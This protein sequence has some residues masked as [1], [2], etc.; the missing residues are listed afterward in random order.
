MRNPH[1]PRQVCAT[2]DSEPRHRQATRL[3]SANPK[4]AN[5]SVKWFTAPCPFY[6]PGRHGR[7][8]PYAPAAAPRRDV[9]QGA[10]KWPPSSCVIWMRRVGRRRA[11]CCWEEAR[12]GVAGAKIMQD[13]ERFPGQQRPLGWGWEKWGRCNIWRA[14]GPD[15]QSAPRRA[16]WPVSAPNPAPSVSLSLCSARL[17]PFHSGFP[18]C[19][20]SPAFLL[21]G[22]PSLP[23]A[24]PRLRHRDLLARLHWLL[25]LRSRLT[26]F[27]FF[28]PGP[29]AGISGDRRARKF[30]KP[31]FVLFFKFDSKINRTRRFPVFQLLYLLRSPYF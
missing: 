16:A 9:T 10:R 24:R 14:R 25:K 21:L 30:P 28:L 15:G 18:A 7:S 5:T 1:R 17:P 2:W 19:S 31:C 12:G 11:V 29:G 22:V 3:H 4:N 13:S 26:P 23:R 20:S 6:S 27:Y 8:S